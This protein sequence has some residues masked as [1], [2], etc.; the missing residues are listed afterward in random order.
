MGL[1]CRSARAGLD[2]LRRLDRPA[3]LLMRDE[4]GREFHAAL[5]AL[6][7]QAATFATGS[8]NRTVALG[9]LAAQWTGQYTL[10]WRMPADAQ[11]YIHMGDRGTAVR[12]LIGQ[13]AQAQGRVADSGKEP[14]FD[15]VLRR[16]VRQFQLAQG[17]IPDGA[18]GPQTAVRLAGVGD[19]SA[20]KLLRSQ[21]GR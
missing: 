18:V 10:L 14:L 16:E 17:L 19:R 21:G 7:D 20:P 3:V 4:Q 1:R 13:L 5:L 8:G 2:E 9:A 12:W 11:E 15:E 6:D